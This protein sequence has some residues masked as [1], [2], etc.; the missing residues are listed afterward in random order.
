MTDII[1]EIVQDVEELFPPKPGGLVDRHRKRKAAEAAEAAEREHEAEP[2]E[3]PAYRAVKVA[4]E[5]PESVSAITYTI[6]A[7]GSAM[8]LPNS[9]YRY[10]ATVLVV[11]S[12][13]TAVLAKDQGQAIGGAG[14]IL[15]ASLPLPLYTRA[16]VWAYNNTGSS[17]QLSVISE[18]YAP[19]QQSAPVRAPRK[20]HAA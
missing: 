11:T 18:I 16:Q 19:E 7:G 5:S 20:H 3:Q 15:P 1:D 17:L 14:F 8:I 13:A 2:V 10:R 6:A 12:A 4:P 9:P